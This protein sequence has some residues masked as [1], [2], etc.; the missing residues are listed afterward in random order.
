MAVSAQGRDRKAWLAIAAVAAA[1]ALVSLASCSGEEPAMKWQQVSRLEAYLDEAGSEL[2]TR[3]VRFGPPADVKKGVTARIMRSVLQ[4]VPGEV[5]WKL[6]L[7]QGEARLE[8]AA[9][10]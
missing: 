6:T 3:A 5:E 7:P 10:F 8:F 4:P 1:L 9:G 2:L